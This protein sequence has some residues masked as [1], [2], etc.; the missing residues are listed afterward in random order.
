MGRTRLSPAQKGALKDL[1]VRGDGRIAAAVMVFDSDSDADEL[2]DTLRRCVHLWV[3]QQGLV[4]PPPSSF[5]LL[6]LTL[7]PAIR[8]QDRRVDRRRRLMRS[9]RDVCPLVVREFA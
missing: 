5:T 8:S 1:I 7:C 9:K 4:C 3:W 2:L 6:T